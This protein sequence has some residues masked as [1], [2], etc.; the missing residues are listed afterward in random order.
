MEN[1]NASSSDRWTTTEAL[2]TLFLSLDPDAEGRV[3]GTKI[4]AWVATRYAEALDTASLVDSWDEADTTKRGSLDE[5]EFLVFAAALEAAAARVAAK[6][7]ASSAADRTPPGAAPGRRADGGRRRGLRGWDAPAAVSVLALVASCLVDDGEDGAW[8]AR[9]RRRRGAS[10]AARRAAPAARRPPGARCSRRSAGPGRRR[11]AE[12]GAGAREPRA[13]ARRD[14]ERVLRREAAFLRSLLVAPVVAGGGA[15]DARQRVALQKA[16]GFLGFE[17]GWLRARERGL[18]TALKGEQADDAETASTL[19]TTAGP[20]SNTDVALRYAKIGTAATAA[21]VV[22]GLTAGLAAPVLAAALAGSTVWGASSLVLFAGTYSTMFAA[23]FGAAGAGLAGYRM[24]RRVAGLKDFGF[25][26]APAPAEQALTVCV[27]VAGSLRE[28]TDYAEAY[29]AAPPADAPLRRRLRR[30]VQQRDCSSVADA[31]A[32]AKAVVDAARL[33]QGSK[34]VIQRRFN[35]SLDVTFGD[36][37]GAKRRESRVSKLVGKMYADQKGDDVEATAKELL[38]L[39]KDELLGAAASGPASRRARRRRRARRARGVRAGLRRA[40]RRR[41]V[42]VR[43]LANSAAVAPLARTPSAPS[44]RRSASGGPRRNPPPPPPASPTG[45]VEED[46]EVA[47]IVRVAAASARAEDAE[48]A[49]GSLDDDD[50]DETEAEDAAAAAARMEA[51]ASRLRESGLVF[52]EAEAGASEGAVAREVEDQDVAKE[53]AVELVDASLDPSLWWWP[54]LYAAGAPELNVL[55]WERDVLVDVTSSMRALAGSLAQS[56]A[57]DAI[58]YGAAT[59]TVGIVLTSLLLPIALLQATQYIDST[60]TLAVERADAAGLALADA[61]CAVD[62]V[63]ARP[64]TLVGYSLGA[65]VVFKCLEE[66]ARRHERARS[67]ALSEALDG[68]THA[69]EGAVDAVNPLRPSTTSLDALDVH[70][71][72]DE[73]DLDDLDH[74]QGYLEVTPVDGVHWV[75]AAAGKKVQ[76]AVR[77]NAAR[78]MA[79]GDDLKPPP[80]RAERAALRRRPRG[81]R[82]RRR[83]PRRRADGRGLRRPHLLA[84]RPQRGRARARG[85]PGQGRRARRRLLRPGEDVG[86]L[87]PDVVRAAAVARTQAWVRRQAARDDPTQP[88]LRFCAFLDDEGNVAATARVTLAWHDDPEVKAQ[89]RR[90]ESYCGIVEHAVLL[91]AP[92]RGTS[93]KAEK[94]RWRAAASVVAGRC[95]NAYSENDLMLAIM[96]RT[97]SW[98]RSVAGIAPVNLPGVEDVDVSDDVASHAAYPARVRALLAK[99]NLDGVV[100]VAS[101]VDAAAMEKEAEERGRATLAAARAASDGAA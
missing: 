54:E 87:R 72:D 27:A 53:E 17:E 70:E 99:I 95:V 79:P 98:S 52:D 84:R 88:T 15:Y 93:S 39:P 44:A 69:L 22:I 55:V 58:V 24:R 92:L 13:R 75:D 14:V 89:R 11:A 62:V 10:A 94:K 37:R 60:W 31:R 67:R 73:D 66:L 35:V 32:A 68:A 71:G 63:G 7:A 101:P 77:V 9:F 61:L 64:V 91:G 3:S 19:A 41:G 56:S 30:F 51:D 26:R 97:Q 5:A 29:G 49:A 65:R 80:S 28:P 12:G 57:Q 8:N 76:L 78:A 90:R 18:A 36:E 42:D 40:A 81:R 47:A 83:R 59:T 21:G 100:Q 48:L 46:V 85:L 82:R 96:Y 43:E 50:D 4:R 16:A 6:L 2:K 38:E 45:V 23:T 20:E 33:D 86:R 34:R 1:V 25:H 74:L